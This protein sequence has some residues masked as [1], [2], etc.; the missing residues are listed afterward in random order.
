MKKFLACVVA[1]GLMQIL[2]EAQTQVLSRNAVGYV[3]ITPERGKLFLGRCDFESIGGGAPAVSNLIGEQLPEG[4]RLY[5]WDRQLLQ[6]KILQ[7]AAR[8]GW[9]AGGSNTIARGEA[10]WI[11]VPPTAT[12][13]SYDV[14]LMGEVPDRFTAP[15]TT[16]LGI[17]GL[18]PLGYPYPVT[19]AWT[20][21]DIS[22]KAPPGS[23]LYLWDATSQSYIVYQKAQRGGWGSGSNVWLTPGVGFW[24]KNT[25]VVDWVEAKP[26]TWP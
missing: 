12:S 18:T 9:G 25:G 14:F 13:N 8:G 22:V 19:V 11:K 15:T 3:K 26:Y 20:S 7:K 2:A 16:I 21:T 23:R 5:L 1:L 4:S 10:F 24:L 17:T 6:Y